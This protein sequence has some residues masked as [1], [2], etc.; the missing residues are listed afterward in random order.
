MRIPN[1]VLN[2]EGY[3]SKI[4]NGELQDESEDLSQDPDSHTYIN[5]DSPDWADLPTVQKRTEEAFTW[6]YKQKGFGAFWSH[7]QTLKRMDE[8]SVEDYGVAKGVLAELVL[9]HTIKEWIKHNNLQNTW[10]IYHSLFVPFKNKQGQTELD[11]VLA[12]RFTV[13]VFEVKSYNGEKTLK[14]EC[15]IVRKSSSR[16]IF[17]QNAMHVRVLKEAMNP[18]TILSDVGAFKSVLFSF[19]TGSINDKRTETYK[20]LMPVV[21]ENSLV[22]FLNSLLAKANRTNWGDNIFNEL[23]SIAD[24]KITMEEHIRFLE[25]R[26]AE[27]QDVEEV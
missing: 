21:D 6:L 25:E 18:E 26:Y 10:K 3:R 20:R 17:K 24:N 27:D 5:P 22:H 19:A 8:L 12:S 7:A 4:Y 1:V 23:D 15:T 13:V 2:I 11:I 16:D 14:G 9:F